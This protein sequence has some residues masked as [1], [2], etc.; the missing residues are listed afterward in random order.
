MHRLP[1][2][3]GSSDVY[4]ILDFETTGLSPDRGDRV[5]EIGISL[6]SDGRE[7]DTFETLVNPGMAIPGF[8]TRLTGIDDRMLRSAPSPGTAFSR[9]QTFI[10]DAQLVAHNASF[11]RKFLRSELRRELGI[12]DTREV[13]CTLML[14]R[15]VF[16]SFASHKLGAIARALEI[17]APRSHRA[18]ADA[19]VTALALA[20]LLER[21]RTAHPHVAID[22]PFLARYQRRAK[23]TLPDLTTGQQSRAVAWRAAQASV[24]SATG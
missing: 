20:I 24:A 16:Q 4:A 1:A 15:R 23:A 12:V 5:I 22:A 9:A 14:S 2:V 13:L 6:L 11:D 7:I 17:P 19:Q 3:P 8:I 10:G 18:L 21:L